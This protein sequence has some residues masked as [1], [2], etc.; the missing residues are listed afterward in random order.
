[1]NTKWE[2]KRSKIKVVYKKHKTPIGKV[3]RNPFNKRNKNSR[4]INFFLTKWSKAEVKFKQ[5]WRKI[6]PSSQKREDLI[7]ISR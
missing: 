1:M 7:Y 3:K 6:L 2:R 4:K 5:R